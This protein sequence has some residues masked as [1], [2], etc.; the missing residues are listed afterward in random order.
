V[1]FQCSNEHECFNYEMCLKTNNLQAT[2]CAKDLF[3]NAGRVIWSGFGRRV[4][5]LTIFG[6]G[7]QIDITCYLSKNVCVVRT[8]TVCLIFHYDKG[9]KEQLKIR[10][11]DK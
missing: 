6:R 7:C 5:G 1:S 11:N 4:D 3:G 10:I 2:R 8:Y 9:E